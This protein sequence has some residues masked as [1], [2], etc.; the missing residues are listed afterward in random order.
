MG[1]E[2]ERVGYRTLGAPP[3]TADVPVDESIDGNGVATVIPLQHAIEGEYA[4]HTPDQSRSRGNAHT[5]E[6]R[7]R[8]D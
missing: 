4:E 7:A 8:A 3:D 6:L 2:P 5:G 1:K